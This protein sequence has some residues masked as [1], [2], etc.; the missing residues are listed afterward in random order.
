MKAVFFFVKLPW[1]IVRLQKLIKNGWSAMREIK[2]LKVT[3][4]TVTPLF[5][6]GA[7][8]RGAPELRALSFRGVLRYWLRVALGGVLG[9]NIEVVRKEE[10]NVFGSSSEGTGQAS[11]IIIRVNEQ[12]PLPKTSYSQIVG[13]KRIGNRKTMEYPGLA[14][15]FFIARGT[16][17]E[18][19]R[20]AL[21]YGTFTLSLSVRPSAKEGYDSLIKAYF[22]LWL[23]THLGGIGSRSRRGAGSLQVISVQG[24]PRFLENLPLLITQAPTPQALKTELEQGLRKIRRVFGTEENQL[25]QVPS[26]FD[27]IHPEACKIWIVD[28]TY[29][30]W[31]QALDEVGKAFRDFRNRRQPDYQTVKN[32]IQYGKPLLKPVERATYGLPIQFYYRSLNNRGAILEGEKH[33]RRASPLIIRVVKLASGQFVTMFIWFNSQLL[34]PGERLQFRGGDKKM[35]AEVPGYKLL[36]DFIEGPDPINHSSLREKGLKVL[37]V[38][39]A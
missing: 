38:D 1:E 24:E 16:R 17:K 22:A 32:S 3:L 8:A 23:F 36:E 12:S 10:E 37:E 6:G 28:R 27:V 4:E 30:T 34:P 13:E 9:G 25:V 19:E 33:E 39:Y 11:T 18:S 7:D 26:S 2:S 5:L 31:K 21:S 15:L 29:S 35:L 14:Y 20:S